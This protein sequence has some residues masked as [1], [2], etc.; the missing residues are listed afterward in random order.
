MSN[1]IYVTTN[2]STARE[3]VKL[4][5]DLKSMNDTERLN[6][7]FSN[8][9]ERNE[10]SNADLVSALKEDLDG[11]LSKCKS[12]LVLVNEEM[13]KENSILNWEINTAV[14]KYKLPIIQSYS[15]FPVELGTMN[16]YRAYW[17]QV[18]RELISSEE[19]RTVHIAYNKK[20]IFECLR[21]YSPSVMPEYVITSK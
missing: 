7:L 12:V 20:I 18:V 6:L 9:F 8:S 15:F 14:K 11:K 3:A 13:V 19:I 1:G 5:A 21:K 4:Y 17:A 2:A 10:D 16:M